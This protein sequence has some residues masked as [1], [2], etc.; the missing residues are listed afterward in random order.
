MCAL[1]VVFIVFVGVGLPFL[2]VKSDERHAGG[3][4]GYGKVHKSYLGR[5]LSIK[6]LKEWH[7]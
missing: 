3:T 6:R 2:S 7:S 4:R 5:C 1:G